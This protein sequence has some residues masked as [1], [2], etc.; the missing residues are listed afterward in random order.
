M[1]LITNFYDS[2][3]PLE[4]NETTLYYNV[5]CVRTVCVCSLSVVEEQNLIFMSIFA[6]KLHSFALNEEGGLWNCMYTSAHPTDDFRPSSR[7]PSWSFCCTVL[8]DVQRNS[9]IFA[10][11]WDVQLWL[12][13]WDDVSL[14][15][16]KLNTFFRE[17]FFSLRPLSAWLHYLIICEV[18]PFK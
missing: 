5:Y 1:K 15:L 10:S 2:R 17:E 4:L 16:F 14:D 9:P 3:P 6:N 18:N 7:V 12:M 11:L 13:G 8:P